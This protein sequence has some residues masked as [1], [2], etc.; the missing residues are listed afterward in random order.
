MNGE[1]VYRFFGGEA[2]FRESIVRALRAARSRWPY[3]A[4]YAGLPDC[5]E[6]ERFI[7]GESRLER[8]TL[9]ALIYALGEPIE[10]ILPF[11]ML[12]TEQ[13]REKWSESLKQS[14]AGVIGSSTGETTVTPFEFF[15]RLEA[16]D[17]FGEPPPPISPGLDRQRKERFQQYRDHLKMKELIV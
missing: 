1:D 8:N 11:K 17:A 4:E 9:H 2:A 10:K 15:I 13:D 16:L 12:P 3:L 5:S 6:I 7:N 14:G